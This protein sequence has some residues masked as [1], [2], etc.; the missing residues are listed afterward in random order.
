MAHGPLP[1]QQIFLLGPQYLSIKASKANRSKCPFILC[2]VLSTKV[3]SLTCRIHWYM[4]RAFMFSPD[5]PP[6][7]IPTISRSP[8][9]LKLQPYDFFKKAFWLKFINWLLSKADSFLPF[10]VL[11]QG[12]VSSNLL[13]SLSDPVCYRTA[14]NSSKSQATHWFP[15]TLS[16]TVVGFWFFVLIL[17]YLLA[18]SG[19]KKK[20]GLYNK[21]DSSSD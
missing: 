17:M 20:G 8:A 7:H 2:T 18:F 19:D 14:R 6:H 13:S 1:T 3:R 12:L 21:P 16:S 15:S 10:H 9:I 11:N 5:G 4:W